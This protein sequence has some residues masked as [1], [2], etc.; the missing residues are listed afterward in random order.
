[1]ELKES[2]KT[3]LTN[4]VNKNYG[5]YVYIP[6][7]NKD[8]DIEPLYKNNGNPVTIGSY[9]ESNPI[10]INIEGGT[11]VTTMAG[12]SGGNTVGVFYNS[13]GANTQ[14][15][16]AVGTASTNSVFPTVTLT[17]SRIKVNGTDGSIIY[18]IPQETGYV[19]GVY[20]SWI[21]GAAKQ[22]KIYPLRFKCS[23]TADSY[24]DYNPS[25]PTASNN[26]YSTNND[27]R[28]RMAN[29]AYTLPSSG[30]AN[31]I[32]GSDKYVQNATDYNKN[33][34]EAL[35]QNKTSASSTPN[36]A[37][38]NSEKAAAQIDYS[39]NYSYA[40]PDKSKPGNS[41][42][43]VGLDMPDK[44]SGNQSAFSGHYLNGS[45]IVSGSK[46]NLAEKATKGVGSGTW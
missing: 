27:N 39:P 46:V 17:S 42:F 28:S 5:G 19:N 11:K 29:V 36:S 37:Y 1:M 30:G 20:V 24:S 3:K 45:D 13:R 2:L 33:K 9:V 44:T 18:T 22:S 23:V 16:G 10:T 38:T 43:S 14:Y 21:K 35:S 7:I 41:G 26:T 40:S 4:F 12:G 8:T 32:G 34:Q 15:G 31:Q 6:G 25:N